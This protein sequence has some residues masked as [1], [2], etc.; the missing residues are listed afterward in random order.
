MKNVD[1][2]SKD[3]QSQELKAKVNKVAA[4]AT[5]RND[6]EL[7]NKYEEDR[8]EITSVRKNN[9]HEMIKAIEYNVEE[10]AEIV[11]LGLIRE[12]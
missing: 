3:F 6:S 7:E 4:F 5:N 10:V 1:K 11:G 2:N 8:I 12:K 9:D